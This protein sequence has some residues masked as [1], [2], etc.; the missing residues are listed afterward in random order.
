MKNG[1]KKDLAN[2]RILVGIN[3]GEFTCHDDQGEV[4]W[5]VGL[6][7]GIHP[8]LAEQLRELMDAGNKFS[9]SGDVT[10][11]KRS[12]GLIVAQGF[13]EDALRSDANPDFVGRPLSPAEVALNKEVEKARKFRK[14]SEKIFREMNNKAVGEKRREAQEKLQ[15]PPET[16]EV[17]PEVTKEPETVKPKVTEGGDA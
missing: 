16:K 10:I 5:S 3:G 17:T 6:L 2:C 12:N 1:I 7:A 4:L 8:L 13:G 15:L 11:K 9:V 14:E